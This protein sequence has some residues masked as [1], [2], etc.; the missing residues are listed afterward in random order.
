MCVFYVGV[1][2]KNG[3]LKEKGQY[4][5]FPLLSTNLMDRRTNNELMLLT[6]SACVV[7]SSVPETITNTTIS[8]GDTIFCYTFL[9]LIL[10]SV[11]ENTH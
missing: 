5:L 7:H 3:D 1:G 2:R 8:Q 11:A 10:V 6:S 4:S 9:D